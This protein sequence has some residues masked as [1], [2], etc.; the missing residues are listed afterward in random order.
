MFSIPPNC[1]DQNVSF[2]IHWNR[3]T[4]QILNMTNIGVGGAIKCTL[5]QVFQIK[6]KMANLADSILKR[7]QAYRDNMGGPYEYGSI[8]IGNCYS[9]Q[10]NYCV[11]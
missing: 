5:W 4:E 2:C 9:Y 6:C 7:F 1:L 10:T 11:F 3:L 8:H